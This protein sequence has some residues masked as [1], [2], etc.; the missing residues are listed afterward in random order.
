MRK[1]LRIRLYFIGHGLIHL[2]SREWL[3]LL[4]MYTWHSRVEIK[5]YYSASY[6]DRITV[7]KVWYCWTFIEGRAHT[8][9]VNLLHL[10][11]KYEPHPYW[12]FSSMTLWTQQCNWNMRWKSSD[13]QWKI[14]YCSMQSLQAMESWGLGTRLLYCSS[15][16]IF[17]RHRVCNSKQWFWL[18]NKQAT[19]KSHPQTSSSAY[20]ASSITH[21]ILKAIHAPVGLGLGPRLATRKLKRSSWLKLPLLS[22]LDT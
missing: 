8:C 3:P 9:L 14:L 15:H 10:P 11:S 22:W 5:D 18:Y 13:Q 2:V 19:R 17:N 1:S 4:Y 20:I 6:F 7:F 12:K 21:G 16:W